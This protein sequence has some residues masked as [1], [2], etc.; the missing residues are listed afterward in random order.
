MAPS[1]DGMYRAVL[2]FGAPGVGKGTQGGILSSVPGFCHVSTGDLFRA[3]DPDSELGK[4]FKHYSSQGLLVPDDFTVRLWEDSMRSWIAEGR[5]TPATELLVL[6]GFPR[7]VSQADM[8]KGKVEVLSVIHLKAKDRDAMVARLKK[9]AIEQGR[10]DDAKEE[11]I[12]NR[13]KVYEDE[14]SP[15]LGCYDGSIV[16]EVDAMGT[17]AEVLHRILAH[18]APVQASHES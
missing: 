12:V 7:N 10:H 17:P 16:H 1:D 15:V 5:Y 9:R 3:L 13:W 8:I 18:V 4:E 11:V 2:L 6:D 14:T